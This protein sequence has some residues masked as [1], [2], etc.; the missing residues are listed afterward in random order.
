MEEKIRFD[1]GTLSLEGLLSRQSGDRGVV[2]THPH[3]LYGG[4]MYNPVVECLQ[5]VFQARGY[6]TLRFNFRGVG[7]SEGSYEDG[8]GEVRDVLA[9][10]AVLQSLGA[11][12]ADLA[13]YSFGAWVNAR[14]PAGQAGVGRSTMVSPPVAF[15]DFSGIEKMSNLSLVVTGSR[16]EIAPAAEIRPLLPAWN[17]G[18]AFEII[19]GADHFYWGHLDALREVLEKHIHRD[20]AVEGS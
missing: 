20:S 4:D 8:T 5:A 1:S 17:P 12:A 9:A 6:T 10:A 16:D 7:A 19:E 15:I 13:G 11:A 18:A 2:I 14:I 3:P